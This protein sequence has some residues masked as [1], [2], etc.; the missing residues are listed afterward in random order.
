MHTQAQMQNREPGIEARTRSRKTSWPP[1]S[2]RTPLCCSRN[3]CRVFAPLCH[4][5][6]KM[7][8]LPR[9]FFPLPLLGAEIIQAKNHLLALVKEYEWIWTFCTQLAGVKETS[10]DL[11]SVCNP[12]SLRGGCGTRARPHALIP[13]LTRA[14]GCRFCTAWLSLR[15]GQTDGARWWQCQQVKQTRLS[16]L[17]CHVS[18]RL[19]HPVCSSQNK[20]MMSERS[21]GVW[22]VSQWERYLTPL[23][24]DFSVV[25]VC[26]ISQ[27]STGT[28]CC[29]Q[30]SG[31]YYRSIFSF[32]ETKHYLVLLLAASEM[33]SILRH[34]NFTVAQRFMIL[35]WHHSCWKKDQV[36][37]SGTLCQ[38]C[39]C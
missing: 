38:H 22:A 19:S 25:P 6:R 24:K 23:K 7:L 26:S 2:I 21:S 32:I 10:V 15:T 5:R 20:F 1:S 27:G 4:S 3:S 11:N 9:F 35:L 31:F 12:L 36:K 28:E 39:F 16:T 29:W 33:T 18:L 8:I 30:Y 17:D 14:C 34:Q 37:T 13:Q